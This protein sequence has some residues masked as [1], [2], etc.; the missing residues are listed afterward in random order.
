MDKTI[1][2]EGKFH[3]NPHILIPV[4]TRFGKLVIAGEPERIKIPNALGWYYYYPCQCDCGT[5]KKIKSQPL[6][7]GVTK[8]CRCLYKEA[9]KNRKSYIDLTGQRFGRLI[10]LTRIA[11]NGKP[12]RWLCQCDC[13][14]QTEV[15]VNQLKSARTKSCGCLRLDIN[16]THDGHK[17]PEYAIWSAIKSR[18]YNPKNK[19]YLNYGGRGIA[20]SNRWLYSFENFIT[21]MGKRPSSKYSIERKDNDGNYDANNCK[22]ATRDEQN[23][24]SRHNVWITYGD[25]TLCLKDW[26]DKIGL[27][28]GTLRSRLKKGWPVEK[29]LTL[30]PR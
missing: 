9:A 20:M 18:C 28:A 30:P 22:W 13:G 2:S 12:G 16:K 29:A 26:A 25:E 4:G 15:A 23:R 8:S 6:L 24:N 11:I 17:D 7:S 10:A 14:N 21:D 3:G 27:H 1:L 19:A 5:L